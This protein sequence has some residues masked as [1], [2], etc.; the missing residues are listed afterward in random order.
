MKQFGWLMLFF[1][2]LQPFCGAIAQPAG[3]KPGL[4]VGTMAPDFTATTYKGGSVT[5][6]NEYKKGPLVLIFY[7]G[8]WCP[9]CNLH[10]KSFQKSLGDF[11]ALGATILAVSVDKPEG[12]ANVVKN[13]ELGFDVIS[14]SQA[15]ILKAYNVVYQVSEE[16]AVKYLNEYKID[17]EA[18]SGRKDHVI[19]VPATYV[20]DTSGKIVFA[21]ANEDYKVRVEPEQVLNILKSLK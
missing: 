1:I 6:S 3:D 9:Y 20:I 17:L 16:L 21:Y 13:N 8:G 10:L 4:S 15:D 7:R 2:L 18:Y 5:L 11:T 14:D 12:A 19:A